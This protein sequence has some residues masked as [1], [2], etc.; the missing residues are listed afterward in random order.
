MNVLRGNGSQNVQDVE[1]RTLL[2][3]HWRGARAALPRKCRQPSHEMQRL[4][5][6]RSAQAL[7]RRAVAVLRTRKGR[8]D[9]V[10]PID[11][12]PEPPSG[13]PAVITVHSSGEG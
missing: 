8:R 10:L 7:A 4:H 1:Q 5:L 6:S 12:I 9:L 11:T 2:R 3:A 13:K